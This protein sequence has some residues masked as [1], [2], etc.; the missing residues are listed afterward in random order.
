MKPTAEPTETP[1][2]TSQLGAAGQGDFAYVY[3]DQDNSFGLAGWLAG[4][5]AFIVQWLSVGPGV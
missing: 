2:P 3:D 5:Q 1:T 4:Q